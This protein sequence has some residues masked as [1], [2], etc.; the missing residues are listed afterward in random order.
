MQKDV[1]CSLVV[2]FAV[3]SVGV[4][5]CAPPLEEIPAPALDEAQPTFRP[6]ATRSQFDERTEAYLDL[7]AR[8]ST[9]S[10]LVDY[11]RNSSLQVVW[12]VMENG[13]IGQAVPSAILL[14]G[15]RLVDPADCNS[16][17]AELIYGAGILAHEITHQ[18]M[19]D[20]RFPSQ[21]G[22]AYRQRA[23]ARAAVV[24]LKVACELMA[25][26]ERA[27]VDYWRRDL[28]DVYASRLPARPWTVAGEFAACAVCRPD[29]E[30]E[31]ARRLLSFPEPV[32]GAAPPGH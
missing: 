17:V 15:N 11:L 25:F 23:E 6:T 10:I 12:V 2:I 9:G 29:V 21:Q 19:G 13:L 4:C 18:A 5:G 14:A 8:S 27:K 3:T 7:L 24:E 22:S 26:Y 1:L 16:P 20:P 32:P 30:W 31:V 28:W